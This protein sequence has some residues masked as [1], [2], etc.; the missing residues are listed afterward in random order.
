ML[1]LRLAGPGDGGEQQ[2]ERRSA[3]QRKSA[4][5]KSWESETAWWGEMAAAAAETSTREA[6]QMSRAVDGP[7]RLADSDDNDDDDGGGQRG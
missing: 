1:L 2:A 3:G 7:A 4:T 6:R 5:E